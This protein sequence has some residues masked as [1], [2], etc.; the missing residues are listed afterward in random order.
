M[1]TAALFTRAKTWKQ[2]ECPLTDEWIKKIDIDIYNGILL[3]KKTEIMPFAATWMDLE[4]II[5]CEVSQTEKD[6]Y[7]MISLICGIYVTNILIY[8][9]GTDR[10]RKQTC[11][12]QWEN[13]YG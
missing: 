12:Y 10:H 3:I 8:K 7:H 6:K 1:F 5:L 2:P 9:T 13:G 11:G 4:I